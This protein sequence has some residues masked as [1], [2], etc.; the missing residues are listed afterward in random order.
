MSKDTAILDKL[1]KL[2]MH[3]TMFID[4]QTEVMR[5]SG[6]LLYITIVKVGSGSMSG[7]PINKSVAST[8]V[9]F[10]HGHM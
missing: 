8:F 10:H 2:A 6:G 5:V 7:F 9:P 1:D 3:E 4:S